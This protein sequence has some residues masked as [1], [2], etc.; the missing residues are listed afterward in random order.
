MGDSVG[1]SGDVSRL[2]S[3]ERYGGLSDFYALASW[4]EIRRSDAVIWGSPQRCIDKIEEMR[5]RLGLT[6]LLCWMRVGTLD[7]RK[8]I[9]S[10]SLM[11]DAVMPPTRR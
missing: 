11:Q 6:T 4:E 3:Y 1:P 10:M 8:V 9:D 2:R 7:H 5:R